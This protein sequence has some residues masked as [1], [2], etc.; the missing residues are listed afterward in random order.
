[1]APAVT[2]PGPTTPQRWRQV[3][4]TVGPDRSWE[5]AMLAWVLTALPMAVQ[6]A[7][8]Q[9]TAASW[10]PAL[11][12]ALVVALVVRVHWLAG[13]VAAVLA[14]PAVMLRDSVFSGPPVLL[15]L[16]VLLLW[17]VATGAVRPGWRWWPGSPAR[18][19]VGL[20]MLTVTAALLFQTGVRLPIAL[21][22]VAGLAVLGCIVAPR[23][24]G[25][26]MSGLDP[27]LA[28]L[29]PVVRVNHWLLE[30]VGHVLGTVLGALAMVPVAVLTGVVW[31]V[32]RV[33]RFDPL[34]PPV[35]DGTRWVERTGEDAEPGRSF[36]KVTVRESRPVGMRVRQ[37]TASVVSV[38]LL[39][40]LLFATVFSVRLLLAGES[41]ADVAAALARR[42]PAAANCRAG[43]DAVMDG[44]ESWPLVGCEDSDLVRAA[45]FDGTTGFRYEDFAGKWVNVTDGVRRTWQ[46]PPCDC[47]RVS[48][49]WFGGSAAWGFYQA[50]MES[51]PSQ[52]AKAAWKQGIALDIVNYATPGWTMGQ[53]VR[54]FAQLSATETPPDLAVFMDGVND[55]TVQFNR[56]YQGA[57]ADESEASFVEGALDTVLRYGKFDGGV[58]KIG[59]SIQGSVP[60]VPNREVG[61]HAVRR[62]AR[63]VK[64]GE[65]AA[66][67]VGTT[68]VFFLQPILVSAPARIGADNAMP[69]RMR[70]ELSQAWPEVRRG[71]PDGVVDLSDVFD[72]VDRKIYKDHV[73]VNEYGAQV[74]AQQMFTDLRPAIEAASSRPPRN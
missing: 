69:P 4:P 29:A 52:V 7:R 43:P 3:P 63:N 21:V 56:N 42:V 73:H 17:T 38:G 68:P 55:L 30:K 18:R 26:A 27:L 12:V 44:Q 5:A 8:L 34:D 22:G 2:A 70:R 58:E 51:V 46:P 6:F 74:L 1:M 59:I 39:L 16:A 71:L 53:G 36:A 47:R 50:D 20:V 11:L 35:H 54:K 10:V 9:Y 19:L 41:V 32:Q 49:W 13:L 67:A 37:L 60:P 45:R 64:V 61:R 15:M 65:N 28:A 24:V 33:V 31:S 57:G 48:V 40:L 23:P 25:R 62:L 66:A 14:V 72:D